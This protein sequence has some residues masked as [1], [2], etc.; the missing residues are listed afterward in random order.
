M[1]PYALIVSMGMVNS[2]AAEVFTVG[3]YTDWPNYAYEDA[4]GLQGI[5]KDIMDWMTASTSAA[6]ADLEFE[7]VKVP[8]S[9][10]WSANTIGKGLE[11]G[12]IDACT[13]YTHTRG[14]RNDYVEFSN[15][16]LDDNKAAGL[17]TLLTDG[18]PTVDGTS[19]LDG[20]TVIDVSGW[21][22]TADT[23]TDVENKCT[24]DKYST[25]VTILT[26]SEQGNDAAMKML[27]DGDGSAM[28]VYAD[29]G[30]N[31][32]C[33]AQGRDRNGN[34]ASWDCELWEGFG[35][36]YAY[37]QTGQTGY[38]FNGTTLLMFKLGSNKSTV[39]DA[40][41]AEFLETEA[42]YNICDKHGFVADCYPNSFF[43]A[44]G[45]STPVYAL[46]TDQ[47]TG[48]CST[49]YCPCSVTSGTTT[50]TTINANVDTSGASS[51][52]LG[53]IMAL[54]LLCCIIQMLQQF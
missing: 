38:S 3:Q 49:G 48:D 28:F 17:L 15:A 22:P 4:T 2:A 9:D 13:T 43:L 39:A 46:E 5:G 42:Y 26:P 24:N 40:C 52:A 47:H 31:Y 21:A 14:I 45:I 36:E 20:V 34:N 54:Q 37:V 27:R 16:F 11:N 51:L 30:M 50:T 1:A 12:T 10:C 6:C 18:K 33:D 7:V 44:G 32:E 35:T 25:G 29:Q 41:M 23:I 19:D 8:W 53:S